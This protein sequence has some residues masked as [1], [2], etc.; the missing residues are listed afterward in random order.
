MLEVW[1]S[2]CQQ[3]IEANE[4]TGDLYL[5]TQALRKKDEQTISA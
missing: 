3:I 2:S 4:P 5:A 1:H